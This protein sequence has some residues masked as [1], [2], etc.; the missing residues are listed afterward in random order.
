VGGLGRLLGSLVGGKS[1]GLESL[2]TEEEKL[3]AGNQV[4]VVVC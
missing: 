3:L 1:L 2:G 4:P